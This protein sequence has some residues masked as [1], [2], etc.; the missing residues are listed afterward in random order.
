MW[1]RYRGGDVREYRGTQSVA[2]HPVNHSSHTRTRGQTCVAIL[3]LTYFRPCIPR[4]NDEK[5]S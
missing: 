1:T 3:Y 4:T 5:G 2:S